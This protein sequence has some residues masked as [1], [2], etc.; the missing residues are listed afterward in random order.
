MFAWHGKILRVNLGTKSIKVESVDEE[1]A[2]K[3]LGG[4]GWAIKY[5]LDEMDPT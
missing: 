1:F 5:L 4:R 2:S 3:Y